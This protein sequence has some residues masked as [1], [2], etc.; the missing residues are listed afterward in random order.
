M[1]SALLTSPSL[2]DADGDGRLEVLA[3]T[4]TDS[5]LFCLNAEDGSELWRVSLG[6]DV[7][8][9]FSGDVDGDGCAEVV[10]GTN[11]G[12]SQ[13]RTLFVLDDQ[14]GASDC[15]SGVEEGSFEGFGLLAAGGKV[16]LRLGHEARVRLELYRASG[17]LE[18]VL[19]D[20]KLPKGKFT[21]EPRLKPGVYL[22]VARVEGRVKALKLAL[23]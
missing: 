20:G 19:V 12:D 3:G 13:G 22:V 2:L 8:S 16:V 10:A 11:G 18:K 1:G 4:Q 5:V 6:V 21:F 9:P 17:R 15:G 23:I 7:H 14:A